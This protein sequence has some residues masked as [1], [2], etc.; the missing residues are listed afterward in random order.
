M[1]PHRPDPK[2]AGDAF[3]F[4]DPRGM[5]WQVLRWIAVPGVILAVVATVFFVKILLVSPRLNPPDELAKLKQEVCA[6]SQQYAFIRHPEADKLW[7]K[8]TPATDQSNTADGKKQHQRPA[9]P[10]APTGWPSIR[11]GYADSW[12]SLSMESLKTRGH[13]LT[14]VSS[15]WFGFGDRAG[16]WIESPHTPVQEWSREKGVR[17]VPILSNLDGNTW[18][19]EPVE[20]LAEASAVI[21]ARCAESLAARLL[22]LGAA[23]VLLD[24]QTVNPG[25]S[26]KIAALI[27]RMTQVMHAHGLELWLSIPMG[28]EMRAFD[29]VLLSD[30]VDYFVAQMHDENAEQDPPGPVASQDW[31]DGWL[32]VIMSQAPAEKWIVS[33]GSYGYDWNLGGGRAET[34]GFADIMSRGAAA[35]VAAVSSQQP[36]LNPSFAYREGEDEHVVWFLDAGTFINQLRA[37]SDEGVAGIG[38]YRLG[39]EDPAVWRTL[40]LADRTVD[41]APLLSEIA[42]LSPDKIVTHVGSGEFVTTDLTHRSGQ[43]DFSS[44]AN[45]RMECHYRVLPHYPT[46]YHKGDGPGDAVC[47]TFDD[48]PDP[49]YTPHILDILKQHGVKACFFIVGSKAEQHPEILRRIYEEGHEIGNHSYTHP[50]FGEISLQRARL[51]LNSTQRLIESITGRSTVL[52]RPPFCGDDK[53]RKLADL[54]PMVTA[55]EM[56][57]VTVLDDVDPQDWSRPNTEEIVARVKALR[58]EGNVVLLHD[59]GGNREQTIEALPAIISWLKKRGDRI[60]LLHELLGSTRDEVMPPVNT[61]APVDRFIAGA[62]FAVGKLYDEWLWSFMI[63]S[64]ALILLRMGTVTFGALRQYQLE[65]ATPDQDFSASVTVVLAAYNEEKVLAATA[66]ALLCSGYRGTMEIIIIN[67]GSTDSTGAIA[68]TLAQQH[69]QIRVIHQNNQGK[70]FALEAGVRSARGDILVF[71][72]AD[73]HF[74]SDTLRKLIAP[75]SDPQVGGVSG[76]VAVGNARNW[77]TRF[78]DLEYTCGFNL[79]RRAYDLW[80]CITVLP[81]ACSAVRREALQRAGGFHHD[82]LAED[83]DLTLSLHRAGWRIRH[84]NDAVADTEAPET[85]RA[86]MRQRFRWSYGTMQCLWKHRDLVLSRDHP[87]LGWFSLPGIWVFQVGLAALAPLVDIGVLMTLATG[88]VAHMLPYL[89]ASLLLELALCAIACGLEKQPLHRAFLSLPARLL[90]RPILS[91]VVWKAVLHAIKGRRAAWNKLERLASLIKHT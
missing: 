6:S 82:T 73:T 84:A 74:R 68:D 88:S 39:W 54:G 51:E 48:G 31:F 55:E 72:D 63:V 64:S 17:W 12:D 19:P 28:L 22:E 52:F 27:V 40:S 7:E 83:T 81:G 10:K 29:I 86:L 43:R 69:S 23:G 79:D 56:G 87:A 59:A 8:F 34:I 67:D 3:V 26:K 11:L 36:Y 18:S 78:Q 70:S 47:L 42:T 46:L 77:L 80:N 37:V 32:R 13:Q 71:L 15:P 45:G 89:V 38:I 91:I 75:M 20:N 21:Q 66:E 33:L 61:D 24:W 4:S 85:V 49:A 9:A 16:Q 35:D 1:N 53:P 5:R 44:D 25:I 76:R 50:H 65:S 58:L 90:Y 60:V 14:H 30:S 41:A 62:G 2:H 57:Y